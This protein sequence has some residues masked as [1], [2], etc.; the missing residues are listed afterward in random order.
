MK[1]N[2]YTLYACM[3]SCPTSNPNKI[4]YCIT[5][6]FG[7]SKARDGIQT[8]TVTYTT[9]AVMLILY[10]QLLSYGLNP[11]CHGDKVRSLTCCTKWK[12]LIYLLITL[13]SLE[14][15]VLEADNMSF[16]RFYFKSQSL[17]YN[18]WRLDEC[19]LSE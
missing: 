4:L 10:P 18:N 3:T 14:E 9:A 2:F 7:I 11:H 16:L 8:S 13:L 15:I 5:M 19:F 12:L 6:T 1:G 17:A